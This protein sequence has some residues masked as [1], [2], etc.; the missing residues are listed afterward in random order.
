MDIALEYLLL[1]LVVPFRCGDHFRHD[2]AT[3]QGTQDADTMTGGAGD[4][5]LDGRGGD[6]VI[7]AAEGNDTVDGGDGLPKITTAAWLAMIL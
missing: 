3:P 5:G 4:E 1:L 2:V 7:A 6:G